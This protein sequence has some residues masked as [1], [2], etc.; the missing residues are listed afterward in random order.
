MSGSMANI[1]RSGSQ[2]GVFDTDA[3]NGYVGLV[4]RDAQGQLLMRLEILETAYSPSILSP[5]EDWLRD[6]DPTRLRIAR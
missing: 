4:V 6:H 1:E 3:P 2:S 5:L